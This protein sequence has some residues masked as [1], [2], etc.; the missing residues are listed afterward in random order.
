MEPIYE[1]YKQYIEANDQVSY[2]TILALKPF[3][4]HGATPN[5]IEV[6]C[7]QHLHAWWAIK[8]LI[9]SANQQSIVIDFETYDS[10]F[11]HIY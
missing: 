11:Q 9:K 2:G 6:C 3:Y 1:L 4:I 5:D 10:F 8:A 7:K